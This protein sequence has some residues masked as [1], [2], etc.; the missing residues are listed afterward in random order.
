[1]YYV[2]TLPGLEPIAWLEMRSRLR[3]A[4]HRGQAFAEEKNGIVFFEHQG[5]AADPLALRTIEDVF[6]QILRVDA[7]SRDYGDLR[8]I[9]RE[10]EQGGE[11]EVALRMWAEACGVDAKSTPTA[12]VVVRKTGEH[13][14][15][16]LDVGRAAE[17]A[18]QAYFG[19]RVR[20]VD[21]GAAL[22]IWVNVLGS[23]LLVGVRMS[24]KRMRHREYKSEHVPASLRPSAA[25][26]L[27]WLT[28]PRPEDVFLDPTCGAG[29]LLAER[30]AFGAARCIVGGD[31]AGGA[32]HAARRNTSAALLRWDAGRLP[33]RAESVDAIACNPPFGK[34]IGTRE[35]A[36]ALYPRLLRETARLLKPGSRAVFITSEY[37]AM[38]DALRNV[39]SL[40]LDRGYS[41]ALLGEWGRVYLLKKV[42]GQSRESE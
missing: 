34:K 15:R 35:S 5:A 18:L 36:H 16:R 10:L 6:V 14:Y 31:I 28:D 9:G 7:L 41:V 20:W 13:A 4:S 23:L 27:V 33:L 11:I 3:R 25:A 2:Q 26:A 37:D 24:D 32:L 29:T 22:E 17:K 30:A 40:T 1:M 39:P 38:R 19:R 12:R 42:E 21:E 8:R